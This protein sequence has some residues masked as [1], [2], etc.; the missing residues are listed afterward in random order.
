MRASVRGAECTVHSHAPVYTGDALSRALCMF[1]LNASAI[2]NNARSDIQCAD[3]VPM[4]ARW[5]GGGEGR[6]G[7]GAGGSWG[8]AEGRIVQK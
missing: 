2:H 5:A 1:W 3:C 7:T 4:F 6:E 8:E